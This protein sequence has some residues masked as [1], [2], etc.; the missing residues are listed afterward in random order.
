MVDEQ[1]ADK[2]SGIQKT[3]MNHLDRSSEMNHL[4]RSSEMNHLDRSSEMNPLDR[5]SEMNLT[6]LTEAV[7]DMAKNMAPGYLVDCVLLDVWK[8]FDKVPHHRSFENRP[9][10]QTTEFGT[11]HW[12]GCR[13]F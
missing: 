2:Y 10:S 4:D 3:V 1:E 6:E 13:Q 8:A 12:D 9:H 11:R 5:S 7:H